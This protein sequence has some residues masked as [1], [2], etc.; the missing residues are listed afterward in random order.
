MET[1]YRSSLAA[2][3]GVRSVV[4]RVTA[5]RWLAAGLAVCVYLLAILGSWV[6]IN[7]G[8]MSCPTWPNCSAHSLLTLYGFPFLESLHRLIA[9]PIVGPLTLIVLALAW[10]NRR[11][12]PQAGRAAWAVIGF[13]ILQIAL[14]GITIFAS[15]DPPSVTAHWTCGMLLLGS[16]IAVAVLAWGPTAA[17]QAERRHPAAATPWLWLAALAALTTTAMGAYVSSSGF[18]LTCSGFPSCDGHW[19]GLAWP[20]GAQMTHRALAYAV[21]FCAVLAVIATLRSQRGDLRAIALIALALV[22]VQIALGVA[23]VLGRLPMP[24]REAHAA[25]ASLLYATYVVLLVRAAFLPQAR[26]TRA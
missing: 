9:G 19:F 5:F 26:A 6:R 12:L 1:Q 25:N 7:N 14:G 13:L 2:R 21:L 10:V 23:N 18:G 11:E 20:Q 22:A 17:E 4:A 24:L 3:A 15:N 16:I 8:G